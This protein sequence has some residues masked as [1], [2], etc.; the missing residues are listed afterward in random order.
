[1]RWFALVFLFISIPLVAKENQ[2]VLVATPL[3]L[4]LS[5]AGP[6]R[7]PLRDMW[8][9]YDNAV[10]QQRY[11][12]DLVAATTGR[13]AGSKDVNG[14]LS[15]RKCDPSNQNDNP[16]FPGKDDYIIFHVLNWNT[17]SGSGLTVSKQNWYVYNID[18]DWDYTRFSNNRIYGKRQV[19]LYTI[20]LNIPTGVTYEERYSVD[21]KSKTPAFLTHLTGLG[22]LFGIAPGGTGRGPQELN[23]WYAFRLDIRSVPSDLQITPAMVPFGSPENAPVSN[24]PNIPEGNKPATKPPQSEPGSLGAPPATVPIPGEPQLNPPAASSQPKSPTKKVGEAAPQPASPQPGAK[25]SVLLDAKTFD[26]EG[27]Y[28]ID[29]S[30]GVPI[31]KISELTYVESS[32]GLAPANVDKQ[33]IFA[34]FDY[35]PV[36]VDVKGTILP[37]YPYLV[38]GVAIGSRPLQ[39]VLF[40]IGWGPIYANFYA[41]LL[42]NTQK[43][44]SG[45]TCGDK[46]P[47]SSTAGAALSN[48]TCPE[49]NFGLN[50][51]V[52]A[53][54]DALKTKSKSSTGK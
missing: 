24:Q 26:N 33:K 13:C 36:P 47:S 19:Y 21:E 35:Y 54:A 46:L 3:P 48:H 14:V 52:G 42:L 7:A 11:V 8:F 39:K 41:A 38:T 44:P 4:D 17:T 18:G 23:G 1:M 28:H 32:N 5:T 9:D 49:F 27:K 31:T 16:T 51:A 15:L 20:H 37:K 25:T 30:V 29:F 10:L 34:L 6:D 2:Y 50:V 40:G 12:L 43:A 22:T 53:I 45:W